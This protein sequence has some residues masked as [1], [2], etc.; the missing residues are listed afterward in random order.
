[1]LVWYHP[2]RSTSRALQRWWRLTVEAPWSRLLKWLMRAR[3]EALAEEGWVPESNSRRSCLLHSF[4]SIWN[5]SFSHDL[6]ISCPFS[7]L[8]PNPLSYETILHSSLFLLGF[9]GSHLSCLMKDH[10]ILLHYLYMCIWLLS[11]PAG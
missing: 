3:C 1:M 7:R 2:S 11:A 10:L 8:T 5:C 4:S 9:Q 6:S